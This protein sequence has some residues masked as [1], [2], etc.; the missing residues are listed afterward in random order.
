MKRIETTTDRMGG[1]NAVYA[2]PL[3]CFGDI[4]MD[5]ATGRYTITISS[6]VG[7]LALPTDG[8]EACSFKETK[9]RDDN[10]DYWQPVVS[11]VIPSPG[12]DNAID[13]EALE[14]GEWL[15]LCEDGLGNL[16]L[17]GDADVQL[18]FATDAGTG[19]SSP[20]RNQVSY[21]FT[22]KLGHPSRILAT[23]LAELFID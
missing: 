11:G 14:R 17:C 22:G 6:T 16:R 3:S 20:E 18:T 1:L 4:E 5:Y 13:I 23:T 15:V 12:V 2:I 9:E 7:V 10:G 19:V 21:T 8:G